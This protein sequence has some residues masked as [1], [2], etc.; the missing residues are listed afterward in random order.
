MF[1]CKVGVHMHKLSS[2]VLTKRAML[3]NVL[4]Q[5]AEPEGAGC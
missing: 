2:E 1:A 4:G 5:V 3:G